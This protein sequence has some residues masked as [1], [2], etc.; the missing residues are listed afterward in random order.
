MDNRP[1]QRER[2][3]AL[4]AYRAETIIY[5]GYPVR[6]GLA[7]LIEDEQ[8]ADVDLLVDIGNRPVTDEPVLPD[9][10]ARL[11]IADAISDGY[12]NQ[13][14]FLTPHYMGREAS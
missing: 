4:D 9:S 7:L 13:Y 6:R 3:N 12:R 2:R 10:H 14:D 1:S 11:L 5:C 8:G